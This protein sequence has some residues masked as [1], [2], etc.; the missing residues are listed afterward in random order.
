V[1]NG[2]AVP[3]RLRHEG[4]ELTFLST[5]TTFGTAVD[6]TA[7]ELSIE[8]FLPADQWTADALRSLGGTG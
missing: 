3:L 1:P 8:S 4:G 6:I 2:I 7:A 5:V